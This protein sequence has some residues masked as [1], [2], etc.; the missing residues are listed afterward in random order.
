[1]KMRLRFTVPSSSPPPPCADEDG[2]KVS[3]TEMSMEMTYDSSTSSRLPPTPGQVVQHLR[4]RDGRSAPSPLS[5]GH[6][7]SNDVDQEGASMT[8][9][10]DTWITTDSAYSDH[11]KHGW[12]Q[13]HSENY[14][15]SFSSSPPP[16]NSAGIAS[17]LSTASMM[18]CS[19]CGQPV[20]ACGGLTSHIDNSIEG[21]VDDNNEVQF[22][23]ESPGEGRMHSESYSDVVQGGM[24]HEM[25]TV[26][27][28]DFDQLDQLHLDGQ[29]DLT[30]EF[31]LQPDPPTSD[32]FSKSSEDCS[33]KKFIPQ[34]TSG[35]SGER[36]W[37][38]PLKT[39]WYD[40]CQNSDCESCMTAFFMSSTESEEMSRQVQISPNGQSKGR[41]AAS[42]TNSKLNKPPR[43]ASAF[44]K[45]VQEAN[46]KRVLELKNVNCDVQTALPPNAQYKPLKPRP[47][48]RQK[49]SIDFYSATRSNKHVEKQN[50]PSK[51]SRPP[52]LGTPGPRMNKVQLSNASTIGN[53]R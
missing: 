33:W 9:G 1:M 19:V 28:E 29:D 32:L 24:L 47:P 7:L 39:Y 43:S 50:S 46:E 18:T 2:T 5:P 40:A 16:K 27:S 37:C 36:G 48:L 52:R 41:K 21:L 49:Y 11:N 26:P 17:I 51:L 34:C 23:H 13:S 22:G 38:A 12:R 45:R 14:L 3:L 25:S 31:Y 44:V 20:G 15:Y 53:L 8:P 30:C 4:P 10:D 6:P 35:C 42:V